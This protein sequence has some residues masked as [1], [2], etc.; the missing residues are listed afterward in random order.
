MT[1][2]D[3][4]DK[5]R[6]KCPFGATPRG[7]ISALHTIP[8]VCSRTIRRISPTSH[9][10]SGVLQTHKTTQNVRRFPAGQRS[11]YKRKTSRSNAIVSLAPLKIEPIQP[12]FP[13]A[14]PH[15]IKNNNFLNLIFLCLVSLCWSFSSRCSALALWSTTHPRSGARGAAVAGADGAET[16]GAA[17][18][19]ARGA[20][21]GEAAGDEVGDGDA[22]KPTENGEDLEA[23]ATDF[24]WNWRRKINMINQK[25]LLKT[26]FVIYKPLDTLQIDL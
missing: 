2:T 14:S 1:S 16:A 19:A 21:D 12:F 23:A 4:A 7:A 15:F 8:A 11:A 26:F 5:A 18:G 6:T 17:D 9:P 3:R 22:D 13:P 10:K 24:Q 20:V 25:N